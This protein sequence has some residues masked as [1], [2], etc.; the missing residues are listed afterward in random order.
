MTAPHSDLPDYC[1]W[2]PEGSRHPCYVPA[3]L[4]LVR[5]TGETL[6]FTCA[7]HA[8]AWASR[9]QGR[10]LMLDRGEWEARGGGYRGVMLGG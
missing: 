1:E 7:E 9:I 2:W 3:S 10:Y 5:A 8:P 4:V 6:R